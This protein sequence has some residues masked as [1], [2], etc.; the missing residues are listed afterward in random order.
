M[1]NKRPIKFFLS[2]EKNGKG[3]PRHMFEIEI[4]DVFDRGRKCKQVGEVDDSIKVEHAEEYEAFVS[5]LKK[6]PAEED[7]PK[8]PSK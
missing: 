6:K 3:E 2:K 8:E 4:A 1:A 7:K 5:S